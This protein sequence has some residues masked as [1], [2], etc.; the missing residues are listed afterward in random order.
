MLRA[1]KVLAIIALFL[2]AG[3][4]G[5]C[6]G[7]GG[8]NSSSGSEPIIPTSDPSVDATRINE[9]EQSVIFGT[10]TSVTFQGKVMLVD[11]LQYKA[12][13]II[14]GV[15]WI[16][17]IPPC[18]N[19]NHTAN[20]GPTS[21]LMVESFFTGNLL[22]KENSKDS[23]ETLIA[24]M[25]GKLSDYN[26]PWR[27]DTCVKCH[28][29]E[30]PDIDYSC[31]DITTDS[32]L[33]TIAEKRGFFVARA[34]QV[35]PIGGKQPIDILKEEIGAGHPIIVRVLYQYNDNT[36]EKMEARNKCVGH[37]MVIVGI[38]T[39]TGYV[40][41]NDPG[42]PWE[43]ENYSPKHN[44]GKNRK[45]KIDSFLEVWGIPDKCGKGKYYNRA[46][47]FYPK[48]TKPKV[49]IVKRSLSLQEGK[50][51][52]QYYAVLSAIDG[53]P[54]YKWSLI[55]GTL[56][57]GLI[58]S[59]DGKITG[60]PKEEGSFSFT[61]KVADSNNTFAEGKISIVISSTTI[62]TPYITTP[63]ELLIGRV[64][65]PYNMGLSASGGIGPY[66][67]SVVAGNL[68]SGL[69]L[70]PE[71]IIKGIPTVAGIYNF[72]VQI[73]DRSFSPQ[74]VSKDFVITILPSNM[75]PIIYSL[76]ANPLSINI[77]NTS[78]LTCNASDPDNDLLTYSWSTTGGSI[79]GS[80]STVKWTAP[81]T[82]GTY[83]VTCNVSDGKGGTASKGVN[84]NVTSTTAQSDLI[85]QNLTVNP[86]SGAVGSNATVSFTIKNQGSGTA[87]ASTTNI[88][89]NTS[90]SGVTPNDYLLASISIPS[91][92]AGGI[93]NVNQTVTIPS[94]RPTGT[95]YI[96][97]ILDV[98]STA[99]QSNE[100]NDKAYTSFN[101][102]STT[103]LSFTNLTPSTITTSIAG[104]QAT[105]SASGTN[106]NNV[107]QVTFVWIGPTNGN[108]AWF[109]GD[110][111]WNS[112]V[113]INSDSSMTLRPVVTNSSDPAGTWTWYVTL[114]DTTGATASRSFTVTYTP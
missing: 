70:T 40:Y 94:G 22:N 113:T 19:W 60:I 64:N 87:N 23:I 3:L 98:N 112:K 32:Q 26:P 111:N 68:P 53:T 106:F 81:S 84:I 89:I 62:P 47:I 20:C 73:V 28:Q 7:G 83:T 107:N 66:V 41:V 92:P 29:K 50:L 75:S 44:Y 8:G 71:G 86:T 104:Y 93:Y 34:G 21:Y 1:N 18:E 76:I 58:L 69:Y 14:E 51:G 63:R 9:E 16:S 54:P 65:I 59:E 91:I 10:S 27:D 97:V 96:W 43:Y 12:A 25:D 6:G 36:G 110:S 85:I 45:Y 37:Y 56:P 95:N 99:N 79:S 5:S 114:T 82:A 72:R 52:E 24:D 35:L 55:D 88:R 67:W 101:V 13:K 33:A 105:L 17:Q 74:T 38:D 30:M 39:D 42:K 48:G 100:T 31:G 57:N 102:T 49:N 4:M 103:V 2:F 78:T 90:S 15:P 108:K 109:R 11:T 61:V 80:G 46:I 77:G